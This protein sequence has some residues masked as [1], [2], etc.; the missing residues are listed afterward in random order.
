MG[1]LSLW[2]KSKIFRKQSLEKKIIQESDLMI[3]HKNKYDEESR[4]YIEAKINFIKLE[5]QKHTLDRGFEYTFEN[6]SRNKYIMI[7]EACVYFK[8]LGFKVH[9]YYDTFDD[10]EIKIYY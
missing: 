9:C 4:V 10:V 8:K 7:K 2:V 3:E 6:I 1:I 5:L